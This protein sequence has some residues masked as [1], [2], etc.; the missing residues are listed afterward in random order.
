MSVSAKA[1]E[2][3]DLVPGERVARK[4]LHEKYGGRAQGG[5]GPSA[6]TSNVMLFSDPVAGERHGYYDGWHGDGRFHYT[7]EG[8]R[9][10]QEMVQGNGAIL[11]HAQ[12]GRALRVFQGARGIVT[13]TGEFV[14]DPEHPWYEADAPETDGGP[15]RKVVVFRLRPVDTA[16]QPADSRLARLIDAATE[17]VRP[18]PIEQQLTE[19]TFIDPNREPYTA[20]R[21][22]SVLVNEFADFLRTKGHVV[23]RH[24]IVPIGES[25]PLFTDLYDQSL[26][27]LV[28]AKGSATRE[29]IRMAIGQLTDYG[30]F[31][32]GAVRAILLPA[33]PRAD[34][35]ALVASAGCIVICPRGRGYATSD[36][37]F[38]V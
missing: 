29:S 30:R 35:R 26:N 11:K 22:E 34:L 38:L 32:P 27:L 21:R 4:A 28:E 3:W 15:I 12:E 17:Q 16:V 37:D 25:R 31:L 23:Y 24:Q 7:G 20:E 2:T 13:Y 18:I 6:K 9:G 5:I 1:T 10:D 14:L 36:P 8:Q 33:E 19:K